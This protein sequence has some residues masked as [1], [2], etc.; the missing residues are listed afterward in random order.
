M[1]SSVTALFRFY[2]ME[3]LCTTE[4]KKAAELGMQQASSQ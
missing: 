1:K 2:A 3:Q 4:E